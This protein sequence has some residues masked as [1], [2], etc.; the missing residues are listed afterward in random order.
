MVHHVRVRFSF[1][2]G[3]GAHYAIRLIGDSSCRSGLPLIC[4]THRPIHN[5]SWR[6][7]AERA[8]PASRWAATERLITCTS[9]SSTRRSYRFRCWS[10]PSRARQVG[11]FAGTGQTSPL[12]IATVFCGRRPISLR[13]PAAR[14]SSSSMSSNRASASSSPKAKGRGLRR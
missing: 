14:R 1:K 11:G 4:G 2:G 10:T 5:P 6:R 9:S 12:A 8:P 7:P 13:Q 3:I